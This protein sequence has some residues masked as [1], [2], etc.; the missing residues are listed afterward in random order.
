[1]KE[2][3]LHPDIKSFIEMKMKE[4][5]DVLN[6]PYNGKTPNASKEKWDMASKMLGY[7]S[8]H[9][10]LRGLLGDE[11]TN[12]FS[13]YLVSRNTRGSNSQSRN[14]LA[15]SMCEI[16]Y[17][18]D[19]SNFSE[20]ELAGYWDYDDCYRDRKMF[21]EPKWFLELQELCKNFPNEKF[22]VVFKG[23]HHISTSY[24][25]RLKNLAEYC[26]L[27]N[28]FTLPQNAVYGKVDLPER[29]R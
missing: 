6:T 29:S 8:D 28:D 10:L 16:E 7:T 25:S 18:V 2:T 9:N 3:I 13:N 11:V 20:N 26:V 14:C 21:M 15:R 27:S 19:I 17:V 24:Y 23:V 4:G 1:M 12:E 22:V 5:T